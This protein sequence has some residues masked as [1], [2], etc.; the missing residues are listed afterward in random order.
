MPLFIL[1]CSSPVQIMRLVSQWDAHR[2]L[3]IDYYHWW[4]FVVE[5]E[6]TN[7]VEIC[8]LAGASVLR[9]K[10]EE[11]EPFSPNGLEPAHPTSEALADQYL[12]GS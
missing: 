8:W 10:S 4:L 7:A 9:S 1:V 6:D 2:L 11:F 5:L 3:F 12:H